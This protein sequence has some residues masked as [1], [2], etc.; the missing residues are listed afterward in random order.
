MS[1]EIII[2]ES[3][4]DI[5]DELTFEDL[6]GF[7]SREIAEIKI[8]ATE[9]T[10]D[11]KINELISYPRISK[12]L[13]Y[14]LPHQTE[15]ALTILRDFNCNALLADEVGLGKTITTG[16]VIREAIETGITKK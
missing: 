16:I 8:K 2:N 6:K 5:E 11:M 14:K 10:A 4:E 13:A 1:E 7:D 9:L 3:F 15:G 12:N